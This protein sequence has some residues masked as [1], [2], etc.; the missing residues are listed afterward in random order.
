MEVDG[1][2][3][4]ISARDLLNNCAMEVF[5][6]SLVS[7]EPSVAPGLVGEPGG[8]KGTLLGRS[9]SQA[10]LSPAP[11]LGRESS[12]CE[13]L[14]SWEDPAGFRRSVDGRSGCLFILPEVRPSGRAGNG[15]AVTIESADNPCTH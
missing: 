7:P 6:I 4:A 10:S 5:V 2:V 14:R 1:E 12:G 13:T 9:E 3:T 15:G 8:S 11:K